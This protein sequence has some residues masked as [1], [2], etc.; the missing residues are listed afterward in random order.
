MA[1]AFVSRRSALAAAALAA[2]SPL[3]TSYAQEARVYVFVMLALVISVGATV[4]ATRRAEAQNRLLILGALGAFV[5]IWLHYTAL[6][7][8]LPL[9]VWVATRP[10]LSVRQ[11]AAFVAVSVIALATVMPLLVVQYHYTPNGGAINGPVNWNNL[12]AVIGTPFATRR[13]AVV[14]PP[15][16]WRT[17]VGALVVLG[18]VLT[19]L[20]RPRKRVS[21]RKLLVALGAVGVLAL[22]AVDLTGKHI[23]ITRY[24]TIT[25]PFLITA[26]VAACAQ[27]P[28]SVA[29]VLAVGAAAVAVAGIVE[30]HRSSGFYP[31]V[32]N[33]IAYVAAREQPGDFMISPGIPL[34]DVPLFYYDTRL[35]DPKLHYFGLTY[36][37]LPQAFSFYKRIWIVDWPQAANNRSALAAIRPILQWFNFRAA[38]VRVY[39]S[40]IPLGVVLAVPNRR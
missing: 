28:R 34:V 21:E 29:S 17:I 20:L 38:S 37:Y 9:T 16:D 8:V 15:V 6:S 19:L 3:I 13:D 1:G 24:T 35:M 12:L 39:S 7:V 14:G 31:P 4:R 10:K 40:S 27:L 32:K 22:I 33:A 11:R 26:I 36:G 5:A 23:L 2:L 18:A 25:A 30:D